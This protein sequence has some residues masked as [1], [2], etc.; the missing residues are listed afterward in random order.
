VFTALRLKPLSIPN[1]SEDQREQVT[2]GQ[3]DR[4]AICGCR[5]AASLP[6]KKKQRRSLAASAFQLALALALLLIVAIVFASTFRAAPYGRSQ[7]TTG[8]TAAPKFDPVRMAPEGCIPSYTFTVA[9]RSF[10]PGVDDIGNHCDDCGTAIA[11][12]F[13]VTLYDQTFT[14]A[15]AGSNGHLTF[16][17]P[18]DDSAITCSPFGNVIAT[19]VMAPY[20]AD[21][22]TTGCGTTA[23]TGCGIFTTTTGIAPNRVFYVEFRT[24]YSSQSTALLDYEIALFENGTPPF[25]Y[26]YGNIIPAPAANDS[27]LVIGVKR[28]DFFACAV[29][30]ANAY[31]DSYADGNSQPHRNAHAHSLRQRHDPKRWI[32]DRQ[33][34]T[35][36]HSRPKRDPRG[37][38]HAGV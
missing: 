30:N 21:Q 3:E 25:Q 38:E 6:M 5:G 19:Y 28:D 23:C 4:A 20:W 8:Q 29:R 16:A 33:L 13:P 27:E 12:P 1:L 26:I 36:D 9:G 10:V 17:I 32:R 11:L 7:V 24:Q 34:P 37:N 31:S 22:C 14:T 18:Y 2:K 15:T 35:V